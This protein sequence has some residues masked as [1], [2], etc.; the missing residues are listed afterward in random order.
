MATKTMDKK[1]VHKEPV[2]AKNLHKYYQM[3]NSKLHVLRG[4]SFSIKKKEFL[5]IMGPSGSGKSTLMNII[6]CLDRFDKGDLWLAG[7]NLNKFSD[8]EL[9]NWRGKQIGFVFQSFNLL[10]RYSVLG[11]V[12]LPSRYVKV[13]KA[14][15]RAKEILN[16]IGLG[17]RMAHKPSELSGGQRQRVAIARALLVN[18]SII[19][20]DEPTGNLD[21]KTG[22]KIMEVLQKLNE[23]GRT[24]VVVTHDP[25]VGK[26]AKRSLI[27]NDGQIVNERFN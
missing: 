21:S 14:E 7:K 8:K 2:V 13:D 10:N 16:D 25:I 27:F 17:D 9:A 24:I 5:A 12:M 6:G 11:N 20:A 4:V 15:E 1:S 23:Q 19:L 18:P 3:G 22:Q 26:I